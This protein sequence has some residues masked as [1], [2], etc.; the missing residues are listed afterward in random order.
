MHK[1]GKRN[2]K[3]E[4]EK[5]LLQ[6]INKRSKRK[7]FTEEELKEFD[8]IFNPIDNDLRRLKK[9]IG[10]EDG[11][12]NKE[13]QKNKN[14]LSN[15]QLR[16]MAVNPKLLLPNEYSRFGFDLNYVATLSEEEIENIN[17][18][19]MEEMIRDEFTTKQQKVK[20][21]SRLVLSCGNGFVDKLLLM[22]IMATEI[23]IGIIITVSIGG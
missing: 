8:N 6:M 15:T 16:M 22:S 11:L 19:I 7:P 21:K 2:E 5:I 13:W 17:K 14:E 23:M 12:L 18:K 10:S 3:N 9:L 1:S 4:I 20:K